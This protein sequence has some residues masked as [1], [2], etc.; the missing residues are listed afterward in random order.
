MKALVGLVLFLVIG[1]AMA[2]DVAGARRPSV[3]D[4]ALG[5]HVSELPATEFSDFACGTNGGNPSVAIADFAGFARCPAEKNG[6]H[7]VY[8]R[9]DDEREYVARANSVP[10]LES[11]S[12][13]K[14]YDRNVIVS[15]L[16]DDRGILQGERIV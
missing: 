12:G 10:Y 6:L 14:E 8:F 16:F 15:A 11:Y 5:K 2:A 13:T 7:E 3:F 9:Y 1:P 4:L